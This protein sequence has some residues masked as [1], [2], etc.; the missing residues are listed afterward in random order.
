MLMVGR[1]L[2]EGITITVPPSDKEQV[3][4]VAAHQIRTTRIKLAIQASDSV[5]IL[6]DELIGQ[7]RSR[8]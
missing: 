8:G 2:G 5:K 7:E 1:K 6:R 3:I 4:H